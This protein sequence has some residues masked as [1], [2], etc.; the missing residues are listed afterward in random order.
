MHLKRSLGLAAVVLAASAILI[1]TAG[2]AQGP[3]KVHR[4]FHFTTTAAVLKYLKAHGVST[5]GIVIQRSRH[6]YAGP[7]CPGKRWSCTKSKRVIQ[8]STSDSSNIFSC[9]PSYAVVPPSV[10][11]PTP[12]SSP[13]DNCVIVQVSVNGTN[14]AKC[15]ETTS[16]PGSDLNCQVWQE[17]VNGANIAT[18]VQLITQRIGQTQQGSEHSNV[19]QQNVSG[20]NTASVLQTI[21]QN[22]FTS[23]AVVN[24]GQT[25]NMDNSI[26]QT[27]G[28]STQ[29][30]TM[31]QLVIQVASAGKSRDEDD[32]HDSH[33]AAPIAPFSTTPFSGS[34]SQFGDGRADVDQQSTGVSRSFNF[35]NMFQKERAP[36]G[37]SQDQE[38]P[39]RCC[40]LQRSNTNDV[41]NIQQ[42]KTQLTSSAAASQ[43]L[44]ENGFLD[45]FG[46]GH[47]SQ[48]GNQ[49]GTTQSNSCDVDHGQCAA[50]IIAEDGTFATC[51]DSGVEV[52][53][54]LCPPI[55]GC[56]GFSLAGRSGGLAAHAPDKSVGAL[57]PLRVHHF[58]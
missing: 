4:Q 43:F 29:L 57:R 54:N 21:W 51:T 20:S 18:T 55:T 27:G 11:A 40:S 25:A 44:D 9:S 19:H 35:Q 58:R 16:A 22:S 8:F 6:N 34:Q 53:C 46:H 15:V 50:E 12:G 28:I 42:S 38:G 7:K 48:F 10:G 24:Q 47:I 36:N 14:N 1:A 2:A 33:E 26:K 23:N 31:S 30:S 17:N 13:P 41:F 3:Q 56:E 49:N 5:R 45:T 32:G 37:V 52:S 39:F